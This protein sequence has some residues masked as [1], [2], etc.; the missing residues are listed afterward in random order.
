M[1][2]LNPVIDIQSSVLAKTFQ[3]W[4]GVSRS[5]CIDDFG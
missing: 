2:D 5:R 4:W 3:I 1:F